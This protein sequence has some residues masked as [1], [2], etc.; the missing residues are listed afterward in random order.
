MPDPPYAT[1]DTP[2]Y[3]EVCA[4][5]DQR[6]RALAGDPTWPT[7]DPDV[8][9]HDPERTVPAF[10]VPDHLFGPWEV[11]E[12]YLRMRRAEPPNQPG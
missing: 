2:I 5:I 9:D 10:W 6:R 7:E 3:R 8:K 12:R 1:S 4:W 11:H